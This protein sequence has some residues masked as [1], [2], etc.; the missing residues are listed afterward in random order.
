MQNVADFAFGNT[1]FQMIWEITYESLL[2]LILFQTQCTGHIKP[3]I[4]KYGWQAY[5][6]QIHNVENVEH[7]HT[8]F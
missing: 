8:G 1:L 3:P 6:T 2:H 7:V 4:N 5:D